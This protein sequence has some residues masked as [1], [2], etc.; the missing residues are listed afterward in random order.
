MQALLF[1]SAGLLD[2][3]CHRPFAA[4]EEAR[5]RQRLMRL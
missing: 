5:K 2:L 4:K 1:M 3:Q